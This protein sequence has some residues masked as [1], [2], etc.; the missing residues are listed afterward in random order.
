MKAFNELGWFLFYL[1]AIL[2]ISYFGNFGGNNHLPSPYDYVC[3]FTL[4]L[5]T[6][7]WS[8]YTATKYNQQNSDELPLE[9]KL[10]RA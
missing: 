2:I 6:L 10:E 9:K 8:T 5:V 3:L 7:R 1:V 4:S